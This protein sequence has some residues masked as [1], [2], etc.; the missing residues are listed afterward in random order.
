M[1]RRSR[2]ARAAPT[3]FAVAL[4]LALAAWLSAGGAAAHGRSLSWSSWRLTTDGAEA[5]VRVPLLELT[6][7]G[8]EPLRDPGAPASIAQRIAAELRLAR[9]GRACEPLG[10]PL[11]AAAPEG[12]AVWEW[13]VRCPRAGSYMLSTRFLLDA[14][15][16][17]L[18]FARVEDA[19]GVVRERVLTDA[20]PSWT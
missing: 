8:I 6:R 9:G 18:H 1:R 3:R 11:P 13:R 17:H 2:A 7:L 12:Q 14:A 20:E 5:R 19:R 10:D 4:V 16:S 15:P